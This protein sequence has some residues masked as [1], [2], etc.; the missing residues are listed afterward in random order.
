MPQLL[1]QGVERRASFYSVNYMKSGAK[2]T[3]GRERGGENVGPALAKSEGGKEEGREEIATRLNEEESDGRGEGQGEGQGEIDKASGDDEK[4]G[5]EE[6]ETR[7]N[8]LLSKRAEGR[9]TKRRKRGAGEKLEEGENSVLPPAASAVKGEKGA[10]RA[11]GKQE[12]L[13]T[14]AGETNKTEAI[15]KQEKA[16]EPLFRF[17][18]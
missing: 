12:R 2:T 1:G 7:G 17:S 3:G 8:D 13:M 11:R 10:K 6:E 18:S 16:D 14:G 4:K 15:E 9:K 5:E